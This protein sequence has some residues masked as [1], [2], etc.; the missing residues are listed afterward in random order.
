MGKNTWIELEWKGQE[1]LVG[2]AVTWAGQ[3]GWNI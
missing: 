3:M 1:I 2:A